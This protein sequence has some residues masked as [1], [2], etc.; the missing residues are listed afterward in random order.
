[1][2]IDG[3]CP[4]RAAARQ[5]NGRLAMPCQQRPEHPET[6][7]HTAH[8][9]IRRARIDN[10]A[11]GQMKRFA[12][13]LRPAICGAFAVHGAVHA[14]IAQNARKQRRIRQGWHIFQRQGF[15]GQQTCDHQRKGCVFRAADGNRAVERMT[16]LNANLVH[17]RSRR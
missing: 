12:D 10:V 1:M 8:H 6:G 3:A 9:V 16:A 7:A 14:M 11:R 2:Q 5:G 4:D 17:S 13:M 15:G